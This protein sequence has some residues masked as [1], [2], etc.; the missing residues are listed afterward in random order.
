MQ[1][2]FHAPLKAQDLSPIRARLFAVNGC[3]NGKLD[4]QGDTG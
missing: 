2:R 3:E 1:N 4:L